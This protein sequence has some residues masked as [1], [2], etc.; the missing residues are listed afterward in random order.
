MTRYLTFSER[1]KVLKLYEKGESMTDIVNLSGRGAATVQR[2]IAGTWRPKLIQNS[3]INVKEK[4]ILLKVKAKR[5]KNLKKMKST[6]SNSV[7]DNSMSRRSS[8]SNNLSSSESST[9]SRNTRFEKCQNSPTSPLS[10][11]QSESNT[12]CGSFASVHDFIDFLCSEE[13]IAM[14]YGW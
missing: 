8:V 2:I 6:A 10:S 7:F 12:F 9:N 11:Q 1:K 13:V 4:D 5:L 3:K 14:C